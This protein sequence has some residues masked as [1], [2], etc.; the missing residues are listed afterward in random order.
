MD[1]YK[2]QSLE[3]YLKYSRKNLLDL[4][5]ASY[6]QTDS[7]PLIRSRVLQIFGQ[8]GIGRFTEKSKKEIFYEV[9]QTRDR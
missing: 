8:N 7:W 9:V 3:E 4:L 5:E 2:N 6:G 1:V